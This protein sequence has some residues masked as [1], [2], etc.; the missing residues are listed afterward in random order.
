MFITGTPKLFAFQLTRHFENYLPHIK[1]HYTNIFIA[2]NLNR[3]STLQPQYDNRKSMK[4][5]ILHANHH[6][7][8]PLTHQINNQKMIQT[9]PSASLTI[10]H[11]QTLHEESTPTT[12][13]VHSYNA[14]CARRHR[15]R[16]R[17]RGKHSRGGRQHS[18][19]QSAA[20]AGAMLS[21]PEL[22]L[23]WLPG[24]VVRSRR[25]EHQ[26]QHQH[27]LRQHL[28]QQQARRHHQRAADLDLIDYP[29]VV[30]WRAHDHHAPIY[31]L[32]METRSVFSWCFSVMVRYSVDV[33]CSGVSRSDRFSVCESGRM[34][35]FFGMRSSLMTYC[36]CWWVLSVCTV[37]VSNVTFV[38]AV[39]IWSRWLKKKL[40]FIYLS[41][42][43]GVLLCFV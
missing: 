8:N 2:K 28:G 41:L 30:Y 42:R 32:V 22:N 23:V 19:R 27:Q 12:R 29:Y 43:F 9:P 37:I 17:G 3:Q 20:R 6:L 40:L 38:F 4:T 24:V 16:W 1:R 39:I 34:C 25:H 5:L 26:H 21:A 36:Q 13:G 15:R 35:V 33:Q 11:S 31:P 18:A 14:S 7:S 10:P